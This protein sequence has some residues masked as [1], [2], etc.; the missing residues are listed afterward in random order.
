MIHALASPRSTEQ[1]FIALIDL[2]AAA[3]QP[4]ARTKVRMPRIE[5]TWDDPDG[6]DAEEDDLVDYGDDDDDL[7]T[8]ACPYCRAEI[9]EEAEQCPECGEYLSQ[10]DE[11]ADFQLPPAWIAVTVAVLLVLIALSLMAGF[12]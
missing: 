4:R 1:R 11:Q 5:E 9:W 3:T 6:W 7:P 10:E 8:V 12:N 2:A